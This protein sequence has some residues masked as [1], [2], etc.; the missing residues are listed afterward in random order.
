MSAR[1]LVEETPVNGAHH[2]HQAACRALHRSLKNWKMRVKGCR[3]GLKELPDTIRAVIQ[4]ELLRT[5]GRCSRPFFRCS[6]WTAS[7]S[8]VL[9][10]DLGVGPSA[11]SPGLDT[12]ASLRAR[13]AEGVRGS[14]AVFVVVTR[15]WVPAHGHW[16]S[17]IGRG[18]PSARP[19]G[20]GRGAPSA[21]P[22][23]E[24]ADAVVNNSLSPDG[25]PGPVCRR[26][27]P[28]RG[29]RGRGGPPRTEPGSPGPGG[30]TRRRSSATPSPPR[31][32]R[33]PPSPT[34]AGT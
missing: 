4:R 33:S 19:A 7:A 12:L 3:R 14:G 16:V 13:P 34:P 23:G 1:R 26:C 31:G 10:R 27:R 8:E 15:G 29:S 9:G 5:S 30:W 11:P 25:P 17:T 32:R 18:A 2:R 24:G 21:R 20:D 28:S 6:H 22:A